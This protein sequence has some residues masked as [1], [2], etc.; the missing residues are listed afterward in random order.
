ML[1]SDVSSGMDRKT[2]SQLKVKQRS[3]RESSLNSDRVASIG[4]I[5]S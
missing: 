3:F 5:F 2:C 1:K 4:S